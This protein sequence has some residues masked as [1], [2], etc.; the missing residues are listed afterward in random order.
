MKK[1]FAL[2]LASVLT[3]SC[4]VTVFAEGPSENTTGAVDMTGC[5]G[6]GY[7]F[8]SAWNLANP[9]CV[10]VD[11]GVKAACEDYG[12]EF[13][14][15][16][17]GPGDAGEEIALIENV[18]NGKYDALLMYPIDGN[19]E[20]PYYEEMTAAGRPVIGVAGFCEA[21]SGQVELNQYGYGQTI[22]QMAA[23]WILENMDGK[24]NIVIMSE[25]KLEQSILRGDGIED[26]LKELLPDSTII[27]REACYTTED[28]LTHMETLLTQRDD[29]NVAVACNDTIGLGA[30]QALVNAGYSGRDDVAVFSGDFTDEVVAFIKEG[31]IYR[32]SVDIEPYWSGYAAAELAIQQLNNGIPDE[33]VVIPGKMS[34]KSQAE[35]VAEA[36]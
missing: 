8:A 10:A 36:E 2:I 12:V 28:G 14:N 13:A 6:E 15:L 32:G 4:G 1:I 34:Y 17:P 29:I 3:F 26:T 21:L 25:D 24:A 31:D 19:A 9:W 16:D 23:D 11:A 7:A 33:M 22:G 35:V 30:Y 20:I 5:S 27:S 18:T